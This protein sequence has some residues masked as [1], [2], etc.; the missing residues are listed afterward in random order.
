MKKITIKLF[1]I[2][3][4]IFFSFGMVYAKKWYEFWKND[5]TKS[6][7]IS[8]SGKA[9]KYIKELKIQQNIKV[10][11]DKISP[12]GTWVIYGREIE[13]PGR[14]KIYRLNLINLNTLKNIPL[15]RKWIDTYSENLTGI[16]WTKD[17]KRLALTMENGRGSKG[18]VVVYAV[19]D[20]KTTI[21]GYSKGNDYYIDYSCYDPSFSSDEKKFLY[22][23][24]YRTNFNNEDK[25]YNYIWVGPAGSTGSCGFPGYVD[26]IIEK[27]RWAEDSNRIFFD[28][29]VTY[30][31]T[32]VLREAACNSNV[33]L[34]FGNSYCCEL[35]YFKAEK[36]AIVK[37]WWDQNKEGYVYNENSQNHYSR[38]FDKEMAYLL[39]E[40][41]QYNSN[42]AKWFCSY[43]ITQ[44]LDEVDT[45]QVE[46]LL[47][48]LLNEEPDDVKYAARFA[49]HIIKH[50]YDNEY[51]IKSPDGKKYAFIMFGNSR[52]NES[53]I[54]V[55]SNGKTE[56]LEAG[57]E[58]GN[59][60]EI[61]WSPDSNKIAYVKNGR[62]WGYISIIDLNSK[63]NC[64]GFETLSFI[65]Q[66][67]KEYNFDTNWSHNRPDPWA[68][69]VKWSDEGN[70]LLLKYSYSGQKYYQGFVVY[71]ITTRKVGKVYMNM[72]DLPKDF[73]W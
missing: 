43:E 41:L 22:M 45:K 40:G 2:I 69:I 67:S 49:L 26:I 70:K 39:L 15:E 9:K 31:A 71:D 46:K 6:P 73:S 20:A 64:G 47:K 37:R 51:F 1:I 52:Y 53:P 8:L 38:F 60:S 57:T 10:Y 34:S 27:P 55:I 11:D 18:M 36:E 17:E 14:Q 50:E 68:D 59:T 48:S 44:F 42:L 66:N 33:D 61:T 58:L 56:R 5:N 65:S 16:A 62:I 54:W 21:T 63:K 23:D 35:K 24:K 29:K 25:N 13:I 30:A 7:I 4:L 72:K 12:L 3:N 32:T 28:Q 19:G